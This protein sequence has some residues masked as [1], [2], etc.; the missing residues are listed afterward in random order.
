MKKIILSIA[1]ALLVTLPA[2]VFAAPTGIQISPLSYNYEIKPGESKEVS[3]NLTNLNSATLNYVIEIE[4]FNQVTD[5]GAPSF[6]NENVDKS[7]T[8]LKDWII[9]K[10]SAENEGQISAKQSK[11]LVFKVSVPVGAEPGG[12]YAAIFAKEIRKTDTGETQLGIATRV[13]TLVLVSVPGEVTKTAEITEF[14]P[15]S[16][17][18]KGGPVDLSMKVKNTGTVHYDSSGSVEIKSM[19]GKKSVVDFGKH[20]IIPDNQRSYSGVWTAKYPFGR[21]VLKAQATDG[22]NQAVS[23]EKVLWVF[24]LIIIIPVIVAIIILVWV[25]IYLRRHVKIV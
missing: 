14:D 10:N 23:V 5:E 12:H 11:D 3:I 17:L 8:S 6:T 9:I 20:T 25:I 21:Y 1:A 15:P 18:W 22:A 16:L 4:N 24:P 7:V 13:G 2:V 19:L